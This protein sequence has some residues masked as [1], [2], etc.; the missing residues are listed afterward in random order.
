MKYFDVHVFHSRKDGYSVFIKTDEKKFLG[1]WGDDEVIQEAYNLGQ[2]D[3]DDIDQVDYVEEITEE[4]YL[5]WSKKG[6]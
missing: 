5:E 1:V 6:N 2:L 4:E 3:A